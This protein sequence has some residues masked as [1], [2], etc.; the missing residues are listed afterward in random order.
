MEALVG[1]WEIEYLFWENLG[2]ISVGIIVMDIP[3]GERKK[4]AENGWCAL[5]ENL[6]NH[7]HEHA[8]NLYKWA[9][10]L[11]SLEK[12]KYSGQLFHYARIPKSSMQHEILPGLKYK[13]DF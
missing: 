3:I 5:Q 8:A 11:A 4:S 13:Y 7:V 6:K 1:L 10:H 12:W 9:S 2:I